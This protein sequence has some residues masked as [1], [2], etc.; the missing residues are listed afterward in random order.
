MQV[1]ITLVPGGRKWAGA[2]RYN[3]RYSVISHSLTKL[4]EGEGGVPI[5]LAA[6][7]AGCVSA[8]RDLPRV[9]EAGLYPAAMVWR[10]AEDA[11]VGPE[12]D[13]GRRGAGGWE[14][15]EDDRQDEGHP[16]D[17]GWDAEPLQRPELRVYDPIRGEKTARCLLE[18]A[19]K[20]PAAVSSTAAI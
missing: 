2:D 3:H 20:T 8:L 14:R 1:W 13:V 6:G 11:T 15:L 7:G 17:I 18:M 5:S 10:L 4:A 19:K 12:G 9:A 16:A